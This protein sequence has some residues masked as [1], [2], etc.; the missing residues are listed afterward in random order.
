[1]ARNGALVPVKKVSIEIDGVMHHGTYYVRDSMVYVD[2]ERGW[3]Q[4]EVGGSTPEVIARMLLSEL[5]RS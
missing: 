4:A 2:A 5:V 1:M 3:K